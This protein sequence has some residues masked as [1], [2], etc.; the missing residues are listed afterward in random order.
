[1]TNIIP[2]KAL[3]IS[4]QALEGE[5]LYGPE[6]M[7]AMA[8]AAEMGGAFGIRANGVGDISAI[9][10]AVRLP[11]IGLN[12]RHIPGFDVYITPTVDDALEVQRAGADIV[13][14]DGTN[15]PR[16]DGL[17]LEE[18]IRVLHHHGVVVMADISTFEEGVRAAGAGANY[19]STTLS[20]YTR[21][22]RQEEGPDIS[23]VKQLA[24]AL[25]TPVVAEGRIHS[26][27]EAVQALQAGAH[28]VVVGS[29]ITRPQ[30]LVKQF[31]E[32]I[33]D[34]SQSATTRR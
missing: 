9:R 18:T 7:A 3:V 27:E 4:C 16:P 11:I 32:K 26:P 8:R 30:L 31:A 20:G 2:E 22:S 24:H 34:W 10:Q 33:A 13:A 5:P 14:I 23:L 21:Y 1:M 15:R 6:I 12:K 28:F 17:S 19:I 25:S 29:A